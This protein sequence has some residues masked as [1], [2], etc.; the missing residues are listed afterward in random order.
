MLYTIGYE[1]LD[2]QTV[3]G[4]LGCVDVSLLL[5]VRWRPSSRKPGL[6]KTA[7]AKRCA[8]LGLVYSHDRRLGTPPAIMRAFRETGHYDWTAYAEFLEAQDEAVMTAAQLVRERTAC[9]LCYEADPADCHRRMVAAALAAGELP[10]VHLR[11]VR[12]ARH[13]ASR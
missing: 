7:L 4:A 12:P 1:G 9:L 10:I 8:T 6:S 3:F 5:D 2:A 13:S 11:P